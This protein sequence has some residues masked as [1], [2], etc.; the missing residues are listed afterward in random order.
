MRILLGHRVERFALL[1]QD[2]G[3]Q[4]V[5]LEEFLI[6]GM[7]KVLR[8]DVGGEDGLELMSEVKVA[9]WSVQKG[10][11]QRRGATLQVQDD[12]PIMLHSLKERDN[13]RRGLE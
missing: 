1:E 13:A 7:R 6:A 9:F 11:S 8:G 5:Q 10:E 4:R 3:K 2:L 12:L